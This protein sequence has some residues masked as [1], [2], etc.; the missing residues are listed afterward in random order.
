MEELYIVIIGAFVS[1]ITQIAKKYNIKSPLVLVAGLS[2]IAGFAYNFAMG[3][4]YITEQLI[5]SV[6][7]SFAYAVAI[8]NTLK[9]FFKGSLK[10]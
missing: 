2:V 10:K 3:R 4:G 8:Y 6:L 1:L 5:K 9:T 7:Q